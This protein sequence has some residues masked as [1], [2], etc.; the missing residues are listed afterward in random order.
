[1]MEVIVDQSVS[2]QAFNSPDW[3]QNNEYERKCHVCSAPSNG[4]H[5][6]APSCSA[7]AAFFRRTVTLNRQFECSH[8]NNCRINYAMRV[9][10]R[11][12][13]YRKCIQAGMDRRAVQP[14]RDSIMGRRKIKYN[15]VVKQSPASSWQCVDSGNQTQYSNVTPANGDKNYVFVEPSN[16]EVTPFVT[17]RS[18]SL[19]SSSS[20][21][22]SVIFEGSQSTTSYIIVEQGTNN[23]CYLQTSSP[24]TYDCH[25]KQFSPGRYN[26]NV[27][28]PYWQSESILQNL[29]AEEC[30]TNERRKILYCDR[31]LDDLLSESDSEI[32]YTL[33]D[34]RPLKFMEIKNDIRS[35]ILVMFEWLR[36]WS[37]FHQLN[38]AE[39]KTLF[40]RCV[41]YHAI[42][43]PAYCTLKIG[44]PERFIMS[45]GMFLSMTEDSNIGWEDEK[46]ISSEIKAMI[47]K[48][49]VKRVVAEII[50]PM[51]EMDLKYEEFCAL[52][53][54]VSWKSAV[55]HMSSPVKDVLNSEINALF[56]SLNQFYVKQGFDDNVIAERIG[57]L[58]LLMS[59]IFSVGMECLENHHK[60]EFFDLWQL[61]SLLIKLLKM[62]K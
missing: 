17:G 46:E 7:C 1:M 6:N 52:K 3:S 27:S 21:A 34:L 13:R 61:D 5:F 31:Y 16:V 57:C 24:T 36:S 18:D 15:T 2:D 62:Q 51:K 48:P 32:P 12:C 42:L 14:R 35:M 53:T 45:N 29:I 58:V 56:A 39:K 8:D 59:N 37:Y 25:P 47:Y 44:Y 60:M 19:S 11:A 50:N 40:R 28:P 54:L 38:T 33:D 9:I 43:D 10:C 22:G 23:N 41:L 4:Y 20:T 26:S 49:L 30:K 55:R